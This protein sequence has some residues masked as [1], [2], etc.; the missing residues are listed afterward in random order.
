[1]DL[2][3]YKYDIQVQDDDA[4]KRNQIFF[5]FMQRT[6]SCVDGLYVWMKISCNR[7]NQKIS[8]E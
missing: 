2:N 1:M 7:Y 6:F 3:R 4:I 8:I 5:N